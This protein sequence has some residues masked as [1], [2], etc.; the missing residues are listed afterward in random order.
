M[1]RPM[2]KYSI[3]KT[4][5]ADLDWL[6]DFENRYRDAFPEGLARLQ[7]SIEIV[8][9]ILPFRETIRGTVNARGAG[10]I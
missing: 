8:L 3:L 7:L 4:R 5:F 9:G 10:R 2:E 1:H 6:C